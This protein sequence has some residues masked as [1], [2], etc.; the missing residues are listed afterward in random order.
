MF[1]PRASIV[2]VCLFTPRAADTGSKPTVAYYIRLHVDPP[3]RKRLKRKWNLKQ[4]TCLDKINILETL[5]MDL[6]MLLT[7][8]RDRQDLHP[9]D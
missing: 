2:S 6:T 4:P 3:V 8:N 9:A 7:I 5:N 1:T